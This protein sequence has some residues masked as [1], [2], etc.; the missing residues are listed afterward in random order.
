[1]SLDNLTLVPLVEGSRWEKRKRLLGLNIELV[2][3]QLVKK[4]RSLARLR[5]RLRRKQLLF[6]LTR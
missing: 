2:A 1:M 6:P 3:N 5:K 4:K